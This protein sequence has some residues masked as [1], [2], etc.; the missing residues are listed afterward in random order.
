MMSLGGRVGSKVTSAVQKN[1]RRIDVF[2]RP[3]DENDMKTSRPAMPASASKSVDGLS[4]FGHGMQ[5]TGNVVCPGALQIFGRITGEIH[6]A[7]LTVGE[8]ARVEGKITAQ[9]TVIQGAFNG[10]IH[11]NFVKLEKTAMVEGEIFNK[12]LTIEQGAQFEGVARRLAE[13][14]EAPSAEQDAAPVLTLAT[15]A[16]EAAE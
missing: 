10:T 12:S 11:G 8:G 15:S 6:A 7:H 14:V 2:S 13:E 16:G 4:T 1:Q 9:E 5:I 3:K